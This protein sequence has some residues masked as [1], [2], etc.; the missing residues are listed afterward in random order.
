MIERE[1]ELGYMPKKLLKIMTEWA[2]LCEQGKIT[3]WEPTA[4]TK[5]REGYYVS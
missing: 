2:D 5:E 3:I 4:E 1:T